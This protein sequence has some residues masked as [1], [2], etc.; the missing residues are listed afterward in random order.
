MTPEDVK[1]Q[2][3]ALRHEVDLISRIR[4]AA[5][6]P[7][8]GGGSRT[9]EMQR[10]ASWE[11]NVHNDEANYTVGNLRFWFKIIENGW[12]RVGYAER[13][14]SG[15]FGGGL[16]SNR[17]YDPFKNITTLQQIDQLFQFMHPEYK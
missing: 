10:I 5:N 17:H 11:F 12:I 9:K 13:F 6:D 2:L 16:T 14:T 15:G 3:N 8:F 7:S 4:E 1:F